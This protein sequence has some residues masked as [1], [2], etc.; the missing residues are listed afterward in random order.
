L[1][2]KDQLKNVA[3][4]CSE[5]NFEENESLRSEVKSMGETIISCENCKHFNQD[6]KCSLDLIDPILSSIDEKLD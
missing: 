3:E 6:H 2:N 4:R 5:Y 1:V